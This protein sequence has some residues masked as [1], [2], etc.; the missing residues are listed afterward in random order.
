MFMTKLKEEVNHYLHFLLMRE[1]KYSEK[2]DGTFW[3]PRQVLYTEGNSKLVGDNVSDAN[4][5]LVEHLED[6][7]LND[8]A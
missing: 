7:F 6:W 2:Q 5:T 1:M 3:L 8:K 4:S